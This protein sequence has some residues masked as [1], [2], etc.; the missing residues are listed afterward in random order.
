[1][2]SSEKAPVKFAHRVG[3][4][5]LIGILL[6]IF[7]FQ[8]LTEVKIGAGDFG[9][10][11]REAAL[12]LRGEKPLSL[13]VGFDWVPYP[14]TAALFG[15]PFCRLQ[16]ELAGALFIGISSGLLGFA[17]T[18][19]GWNR[20]L[21]FASYPYWAAVLTV[22]WSPLMMAAALL[23]WLYPVVIA[24]PNIGFPVALR[25]MHRN[26]LIVAALLTLA[27]LLIQPDWPLVWWKQTRGYQ[28]FIPIWGIGCVLLV[29]LRWA[30][31]DAGSRWLLLM[32][33]IPQR[34][35]YDAFLL[36][37]IPETTA[38]LV[39]AGV[40]SWGAFLATPATRTIQQVALISTVFNYLPMLGIVLVRKYRK[41]AEG[42]S[43]DL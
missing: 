38:E 31:H 8:G 2:P 4:G 24:K 22:Q 7:S 6:A 34:W 21:I 9:W 26:G 37:L 40:L 29:V 25:A 12:L 33:V 36:W 42:E 10:A 13:A 5:I 20:L 17:I 30:R 41:S 28:G 39:A 32:G 11:T 16:P 23:P 3:A 27:T 14:L 43:L 19:R 15:I 35:Y 1:M 18:R